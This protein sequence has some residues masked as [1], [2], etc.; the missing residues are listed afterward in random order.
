MTIMARQRASSANSSIPIRG[1]RDARENC[2]PFHV[3]FVVGTLPAF[4]APQ[5]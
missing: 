5:N 1:A 3:P 2:L 4:I